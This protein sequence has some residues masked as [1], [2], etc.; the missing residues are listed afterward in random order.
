[1]GVTKLSEILGMEIRSFNEGR[2]LK[3]GDFDFWPKSEKFF[4]PKTGVKGR[5]LENLRQALH[6]I[7]P[8]PVKMARE[9]AE[10]GNYKDL[11][12]ASAMAAWIAGYRAAKG[13]P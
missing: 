3:V 4:N 11:S 10:R 5:G 2:H 12:K 6:L 9:Y 13:T 8:D 7:E 1:M